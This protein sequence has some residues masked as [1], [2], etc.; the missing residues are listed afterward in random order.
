ME[1]FWALPLRRQL[2]VAILLLL[3]P[4][5]TAVV[6]SGYVA[7]RERTV[8]LGQQAQII[9]TT[10]AAYIER[11]L[12]NLD[13]MA[14]R[15]TLD[16]ALTGLEAGEARLLFTR[17]VAGRPSVVRVVLADPAG[18]EIARSDMVPDLVD[19]SG[20]PALALRRRER[21]TV[22]V[23]T[24]GP[25]PLRYLVFGYPVPSGAG[26]P[27]AALGV[28][29]NLES[30]QDAFRSLPL[31]DGSVVT[32][33]D[34]EGR[35]LARSI[36]ADR[37][38]GR[39]LNTGTRHTAAPLPS[40]EAMGVDGVNRIYS[41]AMVAAGP[42]IVSVGIPTSLAVDRATSLWTR[43]FSILALGLAGWLIVAAV[44]S[45][46]LG[47][48][49]SHLDAT[50]QRIAAGDFSPMERK[51][52]FSREFAKLQTAFDW[53]LTRFNDTRKALD[54]QMAEERRIRE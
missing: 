11:D 48:D 45:R 32:V 7:L 21:V 35:I 42:W 8:E 44:L 2:F 23:R 54:S 22:P 27:L 10:T 19:E 51:R 36:D 47:K 12:D 13:D 49:A 30:L 52:M 15:I 4:L 16:P 26:E 17:V 34:L 3:V 5:A 40:H 18:D 50:A 41:E 20:W 53:M 46:R 6:W 33:A 31:P 38:V 37:F 9:A 39:S 1:R 14:G 28:Y 43:S 29:V 24:N 25:A